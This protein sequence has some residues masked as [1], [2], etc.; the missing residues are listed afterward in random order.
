MTIWLLGT[1][2]LAPALAVAAAMCCR[3]APG[4]RLVATQLAGAIGALMLVA[5]SFALDQASAIDLAL[6]LSLLT[7]PATLLFA[8]F[9]ERWL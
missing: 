3:G 1:L 8:V 7:L 4:E 9:L 6:T 5:M 2:G